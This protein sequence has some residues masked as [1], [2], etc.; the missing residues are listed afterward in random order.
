[1]SE[2]SPSLRRQIS[3]ILMVLFIASGS[4]VARPKDKDT[5]VAT[6]PFEVILD[7][8]SASEALEYLARAYPNVKFRTHP[9]MN[10]FYAYGGDAETLLSIKRE[11]AWIDLPA[12]R[13]EEPVAIPLW[14]ISAPQ[15]LESL[16][17]R[18][19]DA[20]C[21][22]SGSTLIFRG[23]KA[24][25]MDV[26]VALIRLDVPTIHLQISRAELARIPKGRCRVPARG[27]PY[28]CPGGDCGGVLHKTGL[29][30]G[31]LV[32]SE[33]RRHPYDPFWVVERHGQRMNIFVDFL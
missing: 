1:M 8:A 4:A 17:L 28:V 13:V 23:P 5:R 6:T 14:H 20:D 19:P 22:G 3:L 16:E 33:P 12:I 2:T 7:Y 29:E 26:L 11:M 21:G 18:V 15:A 31:D 32:Q 24:L 30:E 25:R 27:E 10:G 9:T